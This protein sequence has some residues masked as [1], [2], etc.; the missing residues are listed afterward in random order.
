[1]LYTNG[2][3]NSN[4]IVLFECIVNYGKFGT[5]KL[6]LLVRNNALYNLRIK[7]IRFDALYANKYNNFYKLF[8]HDI[9]KDITIHITKKI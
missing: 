9:Q 7:F 3:I 2:L 8:Y 4:W 5:H 6:M 1:M